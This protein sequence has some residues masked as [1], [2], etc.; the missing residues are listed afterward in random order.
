M[1]GGSF[2]KNLNQIVSNKN[3]L[4]IV[5]A[6]AIINLV[7]YLLQNNLA[8]IVLF[9]LIG[10]TITQCTKNMVY[11]L[12][13]A[14]L[15]TNL[16]DKF[17]SY[18]NFGTI[19]GMKNG[20]DGKKKDEDED[21]EDDE[22]NE[23]KKDKKD[24]KDSGSATTLKKASATKTKETSPEMAIAKATAALK[25][26]KPDTKPPSKKKTEKF[27]AYN[28]EDIEFY[29]DDGGIDGV[30]QVNYAK[31]VESAY[32]NLDKLLGSDGIDKMTENTAQ[33]A[34]K[35]EKLLSAMDKMG[36]LLQGAEKM[37]GQLQNSSFGNMLLGTKNQ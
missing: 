35:Q 37:M 16:L 23:D 18:N 2:Q 32:D 10:Y 7:N 13:G 29:E 17:T 26:E 21:D 34:Q 33:L 14:I 30:P 8:A 27:A 9:L 4:Y 6:L 31:T 36:P 19:E 11:V 20:N 24:K 28:E 1:K 25:L 22:D 5:F 12:L 15:L 3:V